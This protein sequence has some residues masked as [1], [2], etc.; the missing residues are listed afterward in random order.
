MI[1]IMTGSKAHLIQLQ[2]IRPVSWIFIQTNFQKGEEF[3]K[4]YFG[5]DLAHFF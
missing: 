3:F 1:I 4:S 2:K 5:V